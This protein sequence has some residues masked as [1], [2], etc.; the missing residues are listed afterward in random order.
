[1]AGLVTV[2]SVTAL[3]EMTVFADEDQVLTLEDEM[4]DTGMLIT[5]GDEQLVTDG[6]EEHI[7]PDDEIGMVGASELP[8]VYRTEGV[9]DIL[10]QGRSNLCWAYSALDAG[11]INQ[12]QR[13]ITSSRSLLYSPGHLGYSAYN[14]PGD[15][16]EYKDTQGANWYGAGG[17]FRLASSALLSWYGAASEA[18]Y[19]TSENLRVSEEKLQDDLTHLTGFQ[20]LPYLF[21]DETNANPM[22]KEWQDAIINMKRHIRDYGCVTMDY[23]AIPGSSVIYHPNKTQQSHQGVIVGWDDEKETGANL[24]GT[25]A[26][27]A[28]LVKNTWGAEK[29]ENGYVWLSYY[30]M[31]M[32]NPIIYQF[33]D[34]TSQNHS[35]NAIF[36]YDATG[37]Y[38]V[39]MHNSLRR[40]ANVF[41]AEHTTTVDSVGL[42]VPMNG[43]YT[44][45]I[46]TDLEDG[47]PGSGHVVAKASGTVENFGFY[48][49][50]VPEVKIKKGESFAVITS[51]KSNTNGNY[52]VFCEGQRTDGT[53]RRVTEA[54][55]GQSFVDGISG[56]SGWHD[57][58]SEVE[59]EQ[60]QNVCVKAYG[61]VSDDDDEVKTKTMYRLYNPNSGE[62]F[63]TANSS[64]QKMLVDIGWKDE[65]T[66]WIAPESSK[67]PVY[68]LYNPNMG[69]H[70]YTKSQA[71]RDMLIG[72]GWKD[73]GIGWYSDDT[74]GTPLYREYNPNQK[75]W[76]HNYTTNQSEHRYLVSIGWKD[77]GIGWYGV[78]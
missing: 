36:S 75:A 62:H 5:T 71:E 38:K 59:N 29:G 56:L 53:L 74:K 48:T 47:R 27:G 12:L 64:E 26:N 43:S 46:E 50:S 14:A 77:E 23:A 39:V 69:D 73:E 51:A 60:L 3:S 58:V 68:R 4:T 37:Y 2:S 7:L 25:A 17:N 65:G 42:Y 15:H 57:T 54:E 35:D 21:K 32:T 45:E 34:T 33:D 8:S 20:E 40:G 72:V 1:M 70:H 49:I 30:D 11:Q 44:V 6:G 76:N 28:F 24:N 66:G 22:S 52:Y 13:G 61:V 55:E 19:P 78:K 67:T 63:Y 16:F 31:S 10:N 9:T 18:S 41:T